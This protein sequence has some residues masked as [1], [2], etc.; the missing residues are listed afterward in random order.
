MWRS[1]RLTL[2]ASGALAL[3]ACSTITPIA[4]TTTPKPQVSAR[5]APRV[6]AGPVQRYEG[7][8]WTTAYTGT[9]R[10]GPCRGSYNGPLE[11]PVLTLE[12]HCDDGVQRA[13]GEGLHTV[14]AHRDYAQGHPALLGDVDAQVERPLGRLGAVVGDAHHPRLQR[15]LRTEARRRHGH[16]ALGVRQ[17]VLRTQADDQAAQ[18]ATVRGA[19]HEQSEVDLVG[20]P[21]QRAAHRAGVEGQDVAVEALEGGDH[22]LA[23][24]AHALGARA[25]GA[26]EDPQDLKRHAEQRRQDVPQ[27]QP[28]G[29][30]VGHVVADG[31]DLS[32]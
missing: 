32:V 29:G 20:G 3:G 24:L 19:E 13:V 7:Q 4:V 28:V 15:A 17:D 18:S 26:G 27:G 11:A 5:N 16:G 22:G 6:P 2:A 23:R 25:R 10:A 31:H 12:L 14:R 8:A 1:S 21:G 9:L 30:F